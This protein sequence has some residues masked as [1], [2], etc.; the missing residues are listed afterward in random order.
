MNKKNDALDIKGFS[1]GFLAERG[2]YASGEALES[3]KKLKATGTEWIALCLVIFQET[4]SSTEI[5]FDYNK[6]PSDMEVMKIIDEAHRLGFKVC[7]KPMIN[8]K[9]G[10][11]RAKIT[12]PDEG[13]YWERWFHS[14]TGFLKHYAEI[15]ENNNCEM[16]CVGCE[17]VGTEHKE[18][19]WRNTI[20]SV[21]KLYGG[22]I[23]Y[24]ANHGKEEGIN[25]WDAVDYLGTS[26]Y[27]PVAEV[28][29]ATEEEMV[30]K[31]ESVKIHIKGLYDQ[32]QKPIVFMEIGC[33][34]ATGCATMPWDFEHTELPH[35]EEEQAKFYES[36]M[37][38]FSYEPW[39]SGFFWW[40]WR[41][42]LYEQE[43]ASMN[44]DFAI[45]GKKAEQ[46]LRKHWLQKDSK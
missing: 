40:D 11:W 4:Y 8:L 37:K 6:T 21:K 25:W 16:F 13:A 22:P 10:L 7:L 24:N 41:H 32:Y 18:D 26:A 1:Y 9:D 30:V 15:A 23:I 27:Y 20:V 33:R 38:V 19:E 44:N 2:D 28:D 36:C 5:K 46:V 12:F 14:Y 31:W 17:M 43:M 42:K 45:Y 39:F 3:L 35:D 34:S 29:G